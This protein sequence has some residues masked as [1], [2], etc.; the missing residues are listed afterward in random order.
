[1]RVAALYDVHGNLAALDAVLAEI[2]DDVDIVVGGDVAAGPYP[3]ESLERLRALGGRVHWIRGNAD[4]ELAHGEE[5]GLAPE[6]MLDWVRSRLSEE[7]IAFLHG[8]PSTIELDVD[9][10]GLVHFCHATPLNDVD[11]FTEHTPEDR[12]APHVESTGPDTI[13]CGHTH[14]QF[15]R[16]VAGK[17]I[18]N[19]GSV[20]MAYE[21][22]P[23][24]YWALFGPDGVEHRRTPFHFDAGDY[25]GEWPSATREEALEFFTSRG[26]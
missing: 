12:V 23:G 14:M 25:P 11:I 4:R 9:G 5:G 13:V 22:E 21:H 24:A 19:A 16:D 15:Q 6:D 17:R 2:P 3:S 1:M 7:Q 10:M 26:L 8:L 18:V 20:G